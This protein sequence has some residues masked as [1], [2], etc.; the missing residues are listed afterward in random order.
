MISG[1]YT[2][3][4]AIWLPQWQRQ[5]NEVE[6]TDGAKQG[7]CT[8]FDKLDRVDSRYGVKHVIHC[9]FRPLAYNELPI[10][11]GAPGSAHVARVMGINSEIPI[12]AIDAH[13]T[14]GCV[15]GLEVSQACDKLRELMLADL[16]GPVFGIRVE[17]RGP[18]APWVHYDNKPVP[19]GGHWYFI[20]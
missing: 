1:G 5:A 8:V 4:E 10:I 14:G 20:P 9:A 2:V 13:P 17:N 3:N 16:L 6:L 11:G 19:P 15:E 18:G 12:G 7:L